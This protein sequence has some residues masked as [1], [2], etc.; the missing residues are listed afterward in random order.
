MSVGK[1][2]VRL[3]VGER[4][5]ESPNVPPSA[6]DRMEPMSS[7]KYLLLQV[8]CGG[9]TVALVLLAACLYSIKPKSIEVSA[10]YTGGHGT[11]GQ[12]GTRRAR[13]ELFHVLN[14]LL[15]VFS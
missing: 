10:F 2:W 7:H 13:K 8:W 12:T 15:C 11:Q 9:L 1:K 3:Q 6:F 14:V 4:N 5:F